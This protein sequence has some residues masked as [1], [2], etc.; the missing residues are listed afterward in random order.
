MAAPCALEPGRQGVDQARQVV[1]GVKG[2]VDHLTARRGERRSGQGL[3][4]LSSEHAGE[5][6]D[7]LVEQLGVDALRPGPALV[8]QVDVKPAQ[9]ADF[10]HV[11]R[12]AHDSGQRPVASSSRRVAGVGAV[13]L[14]PFFAAS[15]GGGARRLG[16]VRLHPGGQHLLDDEAPACATLMGASAA[17]GFGRLFPK[18]SQRQNAFIASRR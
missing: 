15:L 17:N 13:G 11:G 10:K 2:S 18:T 9:G 7:A 6:G 3:A 1:D 8:H 14:G 12:R 16:Q 4:A 5:R